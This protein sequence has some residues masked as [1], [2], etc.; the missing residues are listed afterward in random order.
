MPRVRRISPRS[1]RS[2]PNAPGAAAA[3]SSAFKAA[4]SAFKALCAFDAAPT[5]FRTRLIALKATPIALKATPAAVKAAPAAV[6]A[7][8]AA[9]KAAPAAVKAAPAA[10]RV[11]AAAVAITAAACA[12]ATGCGITA[13]PAAEV[14]RQ[15]DNADPAAKPAIS[16]RDSQRVLA[17]Y[18]AALNRAVTGGDAAAWRAA[19]TGPLA[20]TAAATLRQGG[21][22]P[23][24]PGRYALL[25]PVLHVPRLT[26]YPKWFA[27]AA[28]EQRKAPGNTVQRPVL[29]LFVRRDAARPWQ[30]AYR[31]YLPAKRPPPRAAVDGQGYATTPGALAAPAV[32]PDRVPTTHAAYL[33]DGKPAGVFAAGPYTT[34]LRRAAER[35][36]A[37]ARAGGW[38][39]SQAAAAANHPTYALRAA[40][41]GALVWYAIEETRTL[42]GVPAAQVPADARAYL[43]GRTGRKIE[44]RRL[45]TALA[46]VPPKGEVKVIAGQPTLISATIT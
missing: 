8:P 45:R 1:S 19:L 33:N 34:G 40:D 37:R 9:V 38:R 32:V 27:A 5:T 3:A 21:G 30:A 23:A 25:A 16:T 2:V 7:A 11:T 46:H 28:I 43:A 24:A 17:G 35:E 13:P 26:G 22:R 41:G 20:A 29:L 14:P 12:G 39:A 10:V 15:V 18:M 42:T 44:I 31:L 4:P 36:R 6:K